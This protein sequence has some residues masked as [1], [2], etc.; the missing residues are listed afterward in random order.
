[1]PKNFDSNEFYITVFIFNFKIVFQYILAS[2]LCYISNSFWVIFT[3]YT[4]NELILQYTVFLPHH[5]K[6]L[7]KLDESLPFLILILH[8]V[9]VLCKTGVTKFVWSW[10]IYFWYGCYLKNKRR[11]MIFVIWFCWKTDKSGNG[12]I[13]LEPLIQFVDAHIYM[14]VFIS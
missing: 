1:M 12:Y 11:D 2:S 7:S 6:D 8:Q 14:D 4:N 13:C 3:S 9:Y 10:L 5:L